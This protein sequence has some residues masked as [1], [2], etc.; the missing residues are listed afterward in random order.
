[1]LG[2]HLQSEAVARGERAELYLIAD[3]YDA[4][5][6]RQL[7]IGVE[8]DE[9]LLHRHDQLCGRPIAE[10]PDPFGCHGSYAEHF[11]EAL[12]DRLASIEIRPVVLDAYHAYRTGQYDGFVATTFERFDEIR[13]RLAERF[14]DLGM[15]NLFQ[16]QCPRCRRL[17]TTYVREVQADLVSV[18]CEACEE[19]QTLE[20][21][22]LRGKLSWKLDC[23]AR[24]N[25]YRIEVEAFSKAHLGR[26]ST[27]EVS[28][29]MSEEYYGGTVPEIARYGHVRLSREL[30]GKLLEVLPP[31]VFKG[32][33][34]APFTRDLTLTRETVESFCKRFEV[35][36]GTSY[37]DYVRRTLPRD[38]LRLSPDE[39][40]PGDGAAYIPDRTLVTFGSRFS[41]LFYDHEVEPRMP[42]EEALES[43][44][45]WAIDEAGHVVRCATAAREASEGDEERAHALIRTHLRDRE[46]STEAYLLLRRLFG[47]DRGPSLATV[48]V[49]LPHD[50]LVRAELLLR[51]EDDLSDEVA[52]SSTMVPSSATR[53][54]LDSDRYDDDDSRSGGIS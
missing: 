42:S 13:R 16:V 39:P 2:D 33:F 18:E 50:Y 41:R 53:P 30:S 15:R 22:G 47:L 31:P 21:R 32:L 9:V 36:P 23:A 14:P 24:W 26:W 52:T 17:D 11:T 19:T 28:R 54:F 7:R 6:H 25:L 27:Y 20:W 8:K 10:I 29:F 37:V 51:G 38:A 12:V 43:T 46:T 48:L 3:S 44:P 4:L 40:G 1:V 34:S 5:T 45:Q 35:R 49:T